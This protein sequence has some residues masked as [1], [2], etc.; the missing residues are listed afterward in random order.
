MNIGMKHKTYTN[1]VHELKYKEMIEMLAKICKTTN[2]NH[3]KI[4]IKNM[5]KH[6]INPASLFSPVI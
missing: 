1:D 2:I 3:A 5:T 4:H 6:I